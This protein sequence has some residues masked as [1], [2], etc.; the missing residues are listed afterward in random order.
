MET[1]RVPS[2]DR[3]AIGQLLVRLLHEFRVELAAPR[4]DLG[5]GDIREA[6]ADLRQHRH[7]RH[8]PHRPRRPCSTQPRSDVGT[9]E[10]TS[11]RSATS[12]AAPIPRTVGPNSS[13]SPAWQQLCATR[14]NAS[15]TSAAVGWHRRGT[16]LRGGVRNHPGNCS[17]H[18]IGERST[19]ISLVFVPE[20][21][22]NTRLIV[23]Q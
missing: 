9:R 7:R 21:G 3:Q 4:A 10:R 17:T 5:Y 2:E 19:V 6:H 13:S 11:C 1:S 22:A 20:T 12:T 14:A 16:A 23:G 18:S 8:P 15:H